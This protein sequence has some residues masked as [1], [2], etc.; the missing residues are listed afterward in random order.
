MF[1]AL[2]RRLFN[3][4]ARGVI[5]S[6]KESANLRAQATLLA[7]ETL[8]N[9]EMI[10]EYGY[11]SKPLAGAEAVVIFPAGDRSHGLII[12][13]GDRRYRLQVQAGE[14]ALYDDQGSKVHLK[15]DNTI[16]VSCSTKVLLT[17]PLVEAS[18]DLT[19]KG[20]LTVEGTSDLQD[21]V[22]A[23]STIDADGNVS[24]LGVVQGATISS[25][26]AGVVDVAGKLQD[27]IDI[28]NVHTHEENGDG[29]GTTD[30]PNELIP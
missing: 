20:A 22:T 8:E 7:E 12:A 10:Q 18:Q 17:T 1:K 19:V 14:V 4:I 28:Y 23:G 3:L 6:V 5:K 11:T 24:S 30:L 16:E 9:L 25:S 15:R 27:V 29:G 2:K 26:V 13:T 21:A